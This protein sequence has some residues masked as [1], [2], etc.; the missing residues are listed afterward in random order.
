MLAAL[1]NDAGWTAYTDGIWTEPS[2]PFNGSA[3]VV[4]AWDDTALV[5]PWPR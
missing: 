2:A 5:G 4:T 3:R 1:Y